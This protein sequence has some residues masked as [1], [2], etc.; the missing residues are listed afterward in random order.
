[1]VE[2]TTVA[3]IITTSLTFLL[4]VYQSV[5]SRHF[6]ADCSDCCHVKYE[7]EHQDNNPDN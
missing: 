2:P 4:N 3:L 6:E 5:K 7:S 1:M